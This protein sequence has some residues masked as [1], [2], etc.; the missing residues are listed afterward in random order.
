MVSVEHFQCLPDKPDPSEFVREAYILTFMRGLKYFLPF[1][2]TE[3]R[4]F[5]D[6]SSPGD[7]GANVGPCFCL[8]IKQET[9]LRDCL[10]EELQNGPVKR[11]AVLYPGRQNVMKKPGANGT[12]S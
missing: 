4:S 11:A 12:W 8:E 3:D 2:Q 5:I 7:G 9:A 6:Y 10:R 1:V